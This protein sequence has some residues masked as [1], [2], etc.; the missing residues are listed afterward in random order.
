MASTDL[1][2]YKYSPLTP[3]SRSFRAFRL[4]DRVRQWPALFD[5][6]TLH[7]EIE[8]V[9]V[10]SGDAYECLSYTWGV[11]PGQ[12]PDR[13]VIVETAQK[14]CQLFIH[15][16]LEAALVQMMDNGS[17]SGLLF[18]DQ[19]S[20]DQGNDVEKAEQVP[21]MRDIYANS[22]KTLVW[23]GTE[24][25]LSNRWF[26]YLT[27]IHSEGVLSRLMGPNRGHFIEVFNA[28][29]DPSIPTSGV[30]REDTNDLRA[31][32]DRYAPSFPL[33]AVKEVFSR[34]WFTR[35]WVVQ[36]I[37]LPADVLIIC[38]TRSLCLD[39][40]R[41]GSLFF[42][43]YTSYLPRHV[44]RKET[45]AHI[46]LHFSVLA[47]TQ[48]F[49]RIFQE[50]KSIHLA[51]TK[52]N[53]METVLRYSVV[54]GAPRTGATMPED[55]I[56]AV[57]GLTA[58]GDE[59]H[60]MKVRYKDVIDV[61]TE[62]AAIHTKRNLDI[63]CYVQFPKEND[64]PSWVPDWTTPL[65]TPRAYAKL[66][67]PCFTAGN[68]FGRG[69]E[70]DVDLATR[71][72]TVRGIVVDRIKSI[73]QREFMHDPEQP[74][75]EHLDDRSA[76]LFFNEIDEFLRLAQ[77][78]PGNRFVQ[79]NT[80]VE[81]RADADIRLADRG[82]SE[83]W[84]RSRGYSEAEIRTGLRAA[85]N[86]TTTYGQRL[87]DVDNQVRSYRMDRIFKTVGIVPWYWVPPSE[88]DICYAMVTKPLVTSWN[89]VKGAAMFL[90]D[91]VGLCLASSMTVGVYH[92]VTFRKRF[93]KLNL[94]PSQRE[95]SLR[96]HGLDTMVEHDT[97]VNTLNEYMLKNREQ[98]LYVTEH[99]H[100][101]V[102]PRGMQPDDVVV[103]LFG[104]TTPHVLRLTGNEG[105]GDDEEWAYLGEAYCDGIM[106]GE[107]LR[108][109]EKAE[110]R[111]FR[112][113]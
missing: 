10:D 55:R 15:R 76:R 34:P 63:L 106:D 41:G 8:E 23:L 83:L 75:G 45:R 107:L 104:S 24:T 109:G 17:I 57:L 9:Q 1:A 47:M 44:D 88:T 27:E 31:L 20:L 113:R 51:G 53:S 65:Y 28:V 32:L 40:F 91:V 11:G 81:R 33:E 37:C 93:K 98:R 52:R 26:D 39:C 48:S 87:L 62:F 29:M 5:R 102:G 84:L 60:D 99:G 89:W 13:R 111:S 14:S 50:R 112:I 94:F 108:E 82:L 38:G 30:V 85:K 66:E 64:L 78:I 42:S 79:Y 71:T 69:A 77:D 67:Q 86:H 103:V 6:G 43:T 56:F 92:W 36:E 74:A 25:R 4:L 73:G 100:I 46:A 61:Y 105:C 35:L 110:A 16:S 3:G 72:L 2:D 95:E 7:I 101:G 59:L 12:Q 19:I 97:E 54:D 70:C 58:S 21:L 96:K 90:T 68:A 49:I 18:V 22:A 80:N